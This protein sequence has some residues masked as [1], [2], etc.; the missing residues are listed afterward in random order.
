MTDVWTE[1]LTDA[2]LKMVTASG[3]N[4]RLGEEG[5]GVEL[6]G[7]GAWATARSLVAKGL[8]VIDDG[9]PNGSDLPGLYFNNAEG[10]RIV[11]EF[12]EEEEEGWGCPLCGLHRKHVHVL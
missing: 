1:H 11:H 8:G 6:Q 5:F 9:A 7:S 10:V 2:Q 12:D 4:E 3:H